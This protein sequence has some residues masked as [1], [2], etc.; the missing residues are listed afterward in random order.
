[1]TSRVGQN[2]LSDSDAQTLTHLSE[3]LPGRILDYLGLAI[4]RGDARGTYANW[5]WETAELPHYALRTRLPP[6]AASALSNATPV[7]QKV[8]TTLLATDSVTPLSLLEQLVPS[9]NVRREIV[10]SPLLTLS[11]Q[12]STRIC[13]FKSRIVRDAVLAAVQPNAVHHARLEILGIFQSSPSTARP[14]EHA[15]LLFALNRPMEALEILA[16][17]QA[18]LTL[19]LV[20]VFNPWS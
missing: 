19:S 12:G 13:A 18:T 20:A 8:L 5:T 6:S 7:L 14:E 10:G 17:I 11:T 16:T 3:G 15:A 9:G 1:M 2:A 4:Q